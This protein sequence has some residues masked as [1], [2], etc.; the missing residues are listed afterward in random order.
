VFDVGGEV[1]VVDRVQH[2]HRVALDDLEPGK[3][4]VA[5]IAQHLVD[6]RRAAAD[7][8]A[9]PVGVVLHRLLDAHVHVQRGLGDAL[10][11]LVAQWVTLGR[12]TPALVQ[13]DDRGVERIELLGQAGQAHHV[14]HDLD[15]QGPGNR[16]AEAG[17]PAVAARRVPWAATP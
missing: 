1:T 13:A 5:R 7:H 11:A 17:V 12:E 3:V 14:A 9:Q 15:D 16:A 6:Q 4:H 8:L 2:E 10:V